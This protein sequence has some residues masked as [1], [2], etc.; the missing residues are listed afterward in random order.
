VTIRTILGKPVKHILLALASFCFFLLLAEASLRLLGQSGLSSANLHTRYRMYFRDKNYVE[1][2]RSEAQDR[3]FVTEISSVPRLRLCWAPGLEFYICYEGP[4]QSYFDE[5][6]CVPVEINSKRIRDRED[7]CEPKP[8]GQFRVVCV[9]D[10]FT[11]GWVVRIEDSWVRLIESDLRERTGRDIRSVNCGAFGATVVDEY[12]LALRERF[13]DFEPD[14]VL[15][16][17]CLND[18][19]PSNEALAHHDEARAKAR[20]NSIWNKSRFISMIWSAWDNYPYARHAELQIDPKRDLVGQ[21]NSYDFATLARIGT[22]PAQYGEA[23]FWRGGGPQKGLLDMQAYCHER[24]I[25][26][27]VSI[28]PY[29]QGLSSGE[30]YPFAKMHELV[31]AFCAEHAIPCIDLLPTLKGHATDSLWVSPADYHPN[32][33]AQELVRKPLS[34]FLAELCGL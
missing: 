6:G 25:P 30:H 28:W 17:L 2:D 23:A 18:L 4:R 21:L 8:A 14:A 13:G 33:R 16:S 27:G 26:F 7:L 10:S 24:G 20:R 15:V 29:I 32:D 3:G 19:I 11:F 9:G 12:A 34:D 22:W 31:R 5:H 1:F